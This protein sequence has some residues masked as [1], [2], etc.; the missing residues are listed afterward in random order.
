MRARVLLAAAL[1]LQQGGVGRVLRGHPAARVGQARVGPRSLALAVRSPRGAA[2]R[3]AALR[4]R[5]APV[6]WE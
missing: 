4:A 2:L 5:A 6:E 1:L 3:E